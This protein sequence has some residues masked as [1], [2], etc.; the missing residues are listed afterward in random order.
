MKSLYKPVAAVLLSAAALAV[1]AA[2][3]PMERAKPELQSGG[4]LY[5]VIGASAL[6]RHITESY[7]ALERSV[8]ES[9]MPD[10]DNY[11]S[12]LALLRAV[13]QLVGL[14][15]IAVFGASS[16]RDAG[17]GFSNRMVIAAEPGSSG[18]LWRIHGQSGPRLTRIAEL[19]AD[20]ALAVDFGVDFRPILKD[21]DK[22]GGGEWLAK[23][24]SELPVSQPRKLLESLSGDWRI[25]MIIPDGIEWDYSDPP[26][27]KLKKCDHFISIPDRCDVLKNTLKLFCKLKPS[28]KR[29]GNVI[30]FPG[31]KN[32]VMVFVTL[33][34]RILFFSSVRSFDK[35]CNGSANLRANGKFVPGVKVPKTDGR[36]GTLADD[37]DFAAALKRLPVKSNGAYFINDVRICKVMTIGGQN[38]FRVALPSSTDRS[39]GIWRTDNCMIVNQEIST[40][41]LTV[42]SFEML[43]APP[44]RRIADSIFGEPRT[45]EQKAQ[46]APDDGNDGRSGQEGNKSPSKTETEARR[47]CVERLRKIQSFIADYAKRNPGKL[48]PKLPK[49]YTCGESGYVYF[50]PFA[51]PPSG[52]MPLVADPIRKCPHPGTV[53]VLFVDGSIESFEFDAGSLKRLCSFLHTIYRYDEKEFIRLIERASQLDA[54]KGK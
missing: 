34:H 40:K 24:C 28:V 4:E 47:K 16:I 2:S 27:D 32:S 49:E 19:P 51:A 14:P 48:P 50:A 9:S 7:R 38:G 44:L 39:V 12:I 29:I 6:H 43:V 35:F 22:I 23:H 8:A 10:R 15:E 26:L 36:A 21:I 20:T 25:A 17:A 13:N 3:S 46:D 54:G 33:E 30:Y 11:Q 18:W 5:I 52:K 41:E 53:N 37:P 42:K 31:E 1:G 45:P